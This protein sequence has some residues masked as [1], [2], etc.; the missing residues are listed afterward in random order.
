MKIKVILLTIDRA[1]EIIINSLFSSK[2][3]K[4]ELSLV[5]TREDR[6]YD[7]DGNP[8]V[9]ACKRF[10]LEYL[11]PKRIKKEVDFIKSK[12]PDIIIIAN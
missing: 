5:V 3:I 1:G 9:N 2:K 10:K 6:S 12:N 8:V 4:F 11:Q 7:F